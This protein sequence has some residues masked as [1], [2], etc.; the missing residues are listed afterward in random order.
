MADAQRWKRLDEHT[1]IFEDLEKKLRID[2]AISFIGFSDKFNAMELPMVFTSHGVL[3]CGNRTCGHGHRPGPAVCPSRPSS[4]L[5]LPSR[6]LRRLA[7]R[8]IYLTTSH[9]CPPRTP[10]SRST[11]RAAVLSMSAA[12]VPLANG[13]LPD[14][15]H[16]TPRTPAKPLTSSESFRGE[17]P[18]PPGRARPR[19]RPW[20]P[21]S[22][23]SSYTPAIPA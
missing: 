23:S 16:G 5:P 12:A 21:G 18:R 8:H 3:D 14:T 13:T 2:W 10:S 17:W 15:S 9:H 19:A 20:A 1:V 11:A 7:S 22:E 4:S 6:T